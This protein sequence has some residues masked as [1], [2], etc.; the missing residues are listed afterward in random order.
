[1]FRS[2]RYALAALLLVPAAA[3]ARVDYAIDRLRRSTISAR[4]ARHS[5]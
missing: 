5:R 4:S 2:I 1:M 3:Q